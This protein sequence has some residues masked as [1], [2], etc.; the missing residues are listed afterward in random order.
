[1]I[2]YLSV[3]KMN[4]TSFLSL[5]L[6]PENILTEEDGRRSLKDEK[7]LGKCRKTSL[8]TFLVLFGCFADR[9]ARTHG[10]LQQD[11]GMGKSDAS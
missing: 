1:M 8:R 11:S 7:C 6:A 3:G 10:L 9:K 4:P 2:L 5:D